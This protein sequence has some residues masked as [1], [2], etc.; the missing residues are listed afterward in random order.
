MADGLAGL[1]WI[2][3]LSPFEIGLQ[4]NILSFSLMGPVHSIRIFLFALHMGLAISM[5]LVDMDCIFWLYIWYASGSTLNI[6]V[7]H[8]VCIQ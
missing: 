6:L 3:I 4:R 1:Q 8:P 5:H 7:V 2:N